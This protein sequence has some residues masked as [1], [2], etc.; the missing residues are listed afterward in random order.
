MLGLRRETVPPSLR[1]TELAAR[2]P[3][4][5][6]RFLDSYATQVVVG[7]GNRLLQ[8]HS[9]G[10]E[11]LVVVEGELAVT[12]DGEEIARLGSGEVVGELS[13]LTGNPRNATVIAATDARVYV[14]TR[15][16]FRSMIDTCPE[17]AADVL[18]AM[19]E[20]SGN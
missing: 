3:V 5:E 18:G 8:E 17:I 16:E 15:G 4:A 14:L 10:R 19:V 13:L 12:R 9:H 7:R 20:R 11:C 1:N 2:Y 6:L